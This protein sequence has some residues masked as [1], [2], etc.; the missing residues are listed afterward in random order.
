[1]FLDVSRYC[2]KTVVIVGLS[3][4]P[5]HICLSG[6]SDRFLLRGF[7]IDQRALVSD[8]VTSGFVSCSGVLQYCGTSEFRVVI[9]IECKSE[10]VTEYLV[11]DILRQMSV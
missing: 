8:L 5:L 10:Q 4:A 11:P 6:L 2:L 3:I 1:M 7:Y 9:L